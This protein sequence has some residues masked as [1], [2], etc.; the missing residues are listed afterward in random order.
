MVAQMG[1]QMGGMNVQMGEAN[2]Q[3][4]APGMTMTVSD[5][6]G[7]QMTMATPTAQPQMTMSVNMQQ[8]GQMG[9][10]ATPQVSV[11]VSAPAGTAGVM[12]DA[13]IAAFKAANPEIA[14]FNPD[15]CIA[16]APPP[17]PQI[18]P[19]DVLVRSQLQQAAPN[20]TKEQAMQALDKWA[21]G[22][23]CASHRAVKDVT[24]DSFARADAIDVELLATYEARELR[25]RH[26]PYDGGMISQGM[27]PNPWDLPCQP[28]KWYIEEKKEMPLPGSEVIRICYNCCGGGRVTCPHCHGNGRTRCNH[29]NGRGTLTDAEGHHRDCP[30]CRGGYQRCHRCQESGSIICPTC[31][32]RRQLVHYQAVV[33][34]FHRVEHHKILDFEAAFL[35]DLP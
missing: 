17:P 10:G 24:I 4:S 31:D 26:R 6:Q 21:N 25:P 15:A 16:C 2:V 7:N 35:V 5:G 34:Y 30:H 11:S 33:V 27:S 29:C 19:A 12:T 8:Q 18:N 28:S 3:V 1:M 9:M 13:Q 20:I 22:D 14:S 32:G 23:C